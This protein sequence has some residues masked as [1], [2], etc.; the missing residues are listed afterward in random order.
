MEI[1][2]LCT[3]TTNAANDKSTAMYQVEQQQEAQSSNNETTTTMP[4]YTK[5]AP[6]H[7]DSILDNLLKSDILQ[8]QNTCTA[9]EDLCGQYL[10]RCGK[11]YSEYDT[12][13]EP[14]CYWDHKDTKT[15]FFSKFLTN[16]EIVNLDDYHM[17]TVSEFK[18]KFYSL[19]KI[20]LTAIY[21][22]EQSVRNMKNLIDKV[23]NVKISCGSCH[24]T[25]YDHLPV[26]WPH[27]KKIKISC[28][29]C[30]KEQGLS[31][32]GGNFFK[33]HF[34]NLETLHYDIDL[35]PTNTPVH[36]RN[37]KLYAVP[38]PKNYKKMHLQQIGDL[39][40][41]LNK[42]ENLKRFKCPSEFLLKAR[43]A[44]MFTEKKLEE[45]SLRVTSHTMHDKA[46]TIDV[47][48]KLYEKER[49]KFLNIHLH[50]DY[51]GIITDL[52]KLKI[53][54]KVLTYTFA[55]VPDEMLEHD[56]LQQLTHLETLRVS[57]MGCLPI[58][59]FMCVPSLKTIFITFSDDE[60]EDLNILELNKKR[61]QL[62]NA[63]QVTLYM[64]EDS[65]I[66]LKNK[67]KCLNL[68]HI[69]IKRNRNIGNM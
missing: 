22:T 65:F 46:A 7:W 53:P 5:L 62:K 32:F 59:P 25:T 41:F 29:S 20:D 66:F 30:S 44:F 8:L 52:F 54:I 24:T 2:S 49:Y 56:L 26:H 68:S 51:T 36:L 28:S 15:S 3:T 4:P 9:M 45:L 17:D 18:T 60:F 34:P 13:G 42:H 21:L 37:S 69:I 23:D 39:Q 63:C 57:W 48:A 16:M 14:L 64:C 27:M 19:K 43:K 50:Y 33:Q 58:Y 38:I 11:L 67:Y 31:C 10:T 12:T 55:Y 61:K 47:L 1:D 6:E 35:P 40:T